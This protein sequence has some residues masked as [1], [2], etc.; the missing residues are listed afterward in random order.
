[1]PAADSNE[2]QALL[3]VLTEPAFLVSAGVVRHANA[4]ACRALRSDAASL[5]G[6][7]WSDWCRDADVHS[8]PGRMCPKGGGLDLSVQLERVPLSSLFDCIVARPLGGGREGLAGV[9]SAGR[10]ALLAD[11]RR[12]TGVLL[13][14]LAGPVSRLSL[15]ASAADARLEE[16]SRGNSTWAEVQAEVDSISDAAEELLELFGAVRELARSGPPREP[17]RLPD[18]AE[19]LA[20]TGVPL[21]LPADF[22][23]LHLPGEAPAVLLLF[24]AVASGWSGGA[25]RGPELRVVPCGGATRELHFEWE[26]KDFDAE[27]RELALARVVLTRLGGRLEWRRDDAGGTRV[28]LQL[29]TVQTD[30]P[31]PAAGARSVGDTAQAADFAAEARN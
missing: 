21:A 26:G 8:G 4:S 19:R 5:R 11:V 6:S 15:G 2:L 29:P 13:H 22:H 12:A 27:A 16:L 3:E 7:R 31:A 18:V 17:C 24:A 30:A 14:A 10:P 9:G 20:G 28:I 23:Q 25:V 1:M